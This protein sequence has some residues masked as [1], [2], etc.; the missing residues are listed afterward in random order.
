[1]L[2]NRLAGRFP[3]SIMDASMVALCM[4]S[5]RLVTLPRVGAFALSVSNFRGGLLTALN[6]LYG[7]GE[8]VFLTSDGSG[9]L[10]AA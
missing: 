2:S 3:L 5:G 9:A 10:A 6:L 8:G 1:M 7:R 4:S